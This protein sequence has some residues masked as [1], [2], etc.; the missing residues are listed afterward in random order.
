M[1][2]E[3]YEIGLAVRAFNH[4]DVKSDIPG[5]GRI[6]GIEKIASKLLTARTRQP[7]AMPDRSQGMKLRVLAIVA[8]VLKPGAKLGRVTE[9]LFH[10]C[11]LFRG[12][13][14]GEIVAQCGIVNWCGRW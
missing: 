12:K 5:Q 8:D 11:R 4:F 7:T 14:V 10:S 1:G 3:V 2:L 13:S 9:S 6:E